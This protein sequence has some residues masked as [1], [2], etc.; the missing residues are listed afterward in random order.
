MSM[1]IK[2]WLV[3][4]KQR[5]HGAREWIEANGV[6]DQHPAAFL[7]HLLR[8]YEDHE[9]RLMWAIQIDDKNTAAG[10]IGRV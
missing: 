7:L 5:K 6:T 4:Y 1:K 10:L 3:Y 2:R 9:S 8:K